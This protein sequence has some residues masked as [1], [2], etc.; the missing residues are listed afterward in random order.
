M[1]VAVESGTISTNMA[2][3]QT[4]PN[5]LLRV[6]HWFGRHKVVTV[7]VMLAL[8]LGGYLGISDLSLQAQIRDERARFMYAQQVL[9]G[10][11]DNVSTDGNPKIIKDSRCNYTDNGAVFAVRSLGCSTGFD[12]AYVGL[13]ETDAD[14]RTAELKQL[15]VDAGMVLTENRGGYGENDLMIYAFDI[16]S[17]HCGIGSTYYDETIPDYERYDNAPKTGRALIVDVSCSGSAQAEYF[18]VIEN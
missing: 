11:A 3:M 16:R 6:L 9:Y 8:S 13:P 7:L 18:P 5:A 10:I 2:K 4:R 14:S 1:R 12:V 15:L 17:A